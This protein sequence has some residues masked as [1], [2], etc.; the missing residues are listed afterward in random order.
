MP[1]ALSDEE[2]SASSGDEQIPAKKPQ[3]EKPVEEEEKEDE[4]VDPDAAS[5]DDD[6][7]VV[8]KI[9][10]HKNTKS[11]IMYHVKWQGYDD[12]EDLTWET[13][14]NLEGVV[15]LDE[16]FKTIGG[17]PEAG[18]KKRGRKSAANTEVDAAVAAKR[19]KK[20]PEWS[21]PTGSWEDEVDRVDTVE[22]RLDPKTG[23]SVKYGYLV[24]KRQNKTQHPLHLIFKKCPQKMLA[25]FEEHLVFNSTDDVGDAAG[26]ANGNVNMIGVDDEL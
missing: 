6:E 18:A 23:K 21:P 13:E 16:Y 5:G 22:Q 12:P 3:K 2:V 1:P 14:D 15:A 26:V 4:E 7:Y 11:G 24:W 19:M 8:E 25:Y 20:E 9:I 10:G 17:K